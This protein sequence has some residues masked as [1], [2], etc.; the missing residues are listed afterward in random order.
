MEAKLKSAPGQSRSSASRRLFQTLPR[1]MTFQPLPAY[2]NGTF[3]RLSLQLHASSPSIRAQTGLP[4]SIFDTPGLEA[5]SV[6]WLL[7]SSSSPD[8]NQEKYWSA[9]HRYPI[10]L[11]SLDGVLKEKAGE[12]SPTGGRMAFSG[13]CALSVPETENTTTES[14]ESLLWSK[15]TRRLQMTLNHF[16]DARGKWNEKR[17][18][19]WVRLEPS[20][21]AP[22][23]ATENKGHFK[24][25][26]DGD[27]DPISYTEIWTHVPASPP[28]R[29]TDPEYLVVSCSLAASPTPLSDENALLSSL[30]GMLILSF[31]LCII[32]FGKGR[33]GEGG[34]V[35]QRW[36][37]FDKEGWN[38]VDQWGASKEMV[39]I[40]PEL[41][42]MVEKTWAVGEKVKESEVEGVGKMVW[43]VESVKYRA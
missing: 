18:L 13:L 6:I 24:M 41:V 10:G 16:V 25:I 19:F 36:D 8:Q 11:A 33:P 29:S 14:V 22:G 20:S 15:E 31:P 38:M 43:M 1:K 40:L 2:F 30:H 17:Q 21:S 27:D 35:S 5:D 4:L 26:E 34:F 28:I 37:C 32:Q 9:T 39:A 7:C 12:K 42:K 23:N 3:H